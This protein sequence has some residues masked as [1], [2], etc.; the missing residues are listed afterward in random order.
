M[1]SVRPFVLLLFF[2]SVRK[3]VYCMNKYQNMYTNY[4]IFIFRNPNTMAI[5]IATYRCVFVNA[6]HDN[7]QHFKTL[8]PVERKKMNTPR[9]FNTF[10]RLCNDTLIDYMFN[11]EIETTNFHFC[12]WK[13]LLVNNWSRFGFH[14]HGTNPTFFAV[15]PFGFN[16]NA[17]L[18]KR[19]F[20]FGTLLICLLTATFPAKWI[21][22][23]LKSYWN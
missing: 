14:T 9:L 11:S 17:A 15:N 7:G 2:G 21:V 8:L 20:T 18:V 10:Y 3:S 16:I 5:F 12:C 1:S 19:A 4:S 23:E 22:F 13:P 6:F